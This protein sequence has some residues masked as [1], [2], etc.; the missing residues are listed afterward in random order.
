MNAEAESEEL[1]PDT[2]DRL[3]HASIAAAVACILCVVIFVLTPWF[4]HGGLRPVAR[5]GMVFVVL[6]APV[7]SFLWWQRLRPPEEEE[8]VSLA[9]VLKF[10]ELELIEDATITML[11]DTATKIEEFDKAEAGKVDAIAIVYEL[12]S[13][14][15]SL[16]ASDVHMTPEQDG[17]RFTY[18]IDG[19]LYDVGYVS[20]RHLPFVINRVKV[21]ASLLIHVHAKPQ[22]GRF[23]F[24]RDEFQA[25]V[26]TLPTNHGEKVVIRLAI[27]DETRYAL[28]RVG[29]EDETLVLYKTLLLREHGLVYLTGPT[30]SGKTTTLYA[31]LTHIRDTKSD[32]LNIVTLEDPMEVDFRG[33]AQTQVNNLVGL[34]FADGLRSILRQ[35][36]DVIMVGEIRDE[37]TA[38][39]A[40]RAGLTGHLLL[41]TVHADSTAGVFQRLM[42][43][44]V[45][46][47]Q[48]AGASIAVVN[49]R[50]AIRNCPTCV[51]E[52]PLTELQQKQ[53]VMLGIADTPELAGPFYEG[54]GCGA[55]RGKGR[56]GRVPLIEVLKVD[57]GIR[58]A[59]LAKTS[60]HELESL[61]VEGGMSTLADQAMARAAR[62]ELP[63]DEVIR[64][65]SV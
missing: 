32:K 27:N 57:D 43:L 54:K 13:T 29:F 1:D 59:I 8:A 25:R 44:N 6:A 63:I 36:P 15:F 62:G 2:P 24:D 5:I 50:L 3:V 35:D 48:V 17:L 31:S 49:Q 11:N 39:T 60:K 7:L 34:T 65:L 56:F 30:G 33:V 42:Q 52:S 61:A 16:A 53:L 38:Q 14:G 22:D 9:H 64:V 26:S 47:F 58:D 18:R 23:T 10:D 19:V 40:I 37:E 46:P 45:D 41:T 21:L 4:L 51:V 28:D 12:L 20:R 55:C